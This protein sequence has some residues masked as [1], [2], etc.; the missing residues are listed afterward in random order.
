[1]SCQ[2]AAMY[3]L[4][5]RRSGECADD[6]Q[7][8]LY[9]FFRSLSI[10]NIVTLFEFALAESRIIL[11]S[12]HTSMLQLVSRALV[13]LMYPLKW[14][15]IFIPVLPARLLSALEVGFSRWLWWWCGSLR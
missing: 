1:M 5:S 8:D 11:L 3:G 6:I 7:V 15:G 10:P 2:S 9:G 12:S 13:S 14:L 4:V